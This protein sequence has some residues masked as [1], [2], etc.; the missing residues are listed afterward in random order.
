MNFKG[1]RACRAAAGAKAFATEEPRE[2]STRHFLFQATAL[3][4]VVGF[5]Q[6]SATGSFANAMHC[7]LRSSKVAGDL[8]GADHGN[9][10]NP[11]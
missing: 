4:I 1:S 10:G 6:P 8:D 5:L 2:A 3:L 9:S 11:F 7:R